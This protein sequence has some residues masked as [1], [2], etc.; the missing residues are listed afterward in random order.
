[1]G[2]NPV[3]TRV[4]FCEI[5]LVVELALLIAF[6][7]YPARHEARANA[8]HV[9]EAER[10]IA[11]DFD[12]EAALNGTSTRRRAGTMQLRTEPVDLL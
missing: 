10:A 7:V 9:S 4:V 11:S 5:F 1:M 8:L 3:P 12:F 6:S 2:Q